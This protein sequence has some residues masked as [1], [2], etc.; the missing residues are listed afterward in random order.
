[1]PELNFAE[2]GTIYDLEK[3]FGTH[4]RTVPISEAIPTIANICVKNILAR[5]NQVK[6]ENGSHKRS[7]PF[8]QRFGPIGAGA[9]PATHM[10]G[11]INQ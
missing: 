11:P 2:R 1:V 4:Y 7:P 10:P 8:S 3:D 6:Y 5:Q 9:I